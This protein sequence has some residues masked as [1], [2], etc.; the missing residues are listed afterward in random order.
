MIKIEL[1]FVL[2]FIILIIN[3]L[4]DFSMIAWSI[5]FNRNSSLHEGRLLSSSEVILR[6]TSMWVHFRYAQPEAVTLISQVSLPSQW[7][8]PPSGYVKINVDAVV[9]GFQRVGIGVV[10]RDDQGLVLH[11]QFSYVEGVYS[12]HVA[13]LLAAREGKI[14]AS[15]LLGLILFL[16]LMV[17]T[18]S[19]LSTLIFLLPMTNQY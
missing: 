1:E 12:A 11:S 13:E 16:S 3:D 8:A 10:A 18:S 7:S 4:G 15:M 6:V 2:N 14:V 5:W 9:Q 19:I 17:V